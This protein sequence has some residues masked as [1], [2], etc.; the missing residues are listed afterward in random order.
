MQYHA[1]RD[2]D[3]RYS[4]QGFSLIELMIV[5]AIIGILAAVVLPAYSDYTKR[6]KMTEVIMAASACRTAITEVYQNAPIS[7][8]VQD[9]WGCEQVSSP[10]KNV[11]SVRTVDYGHIIVTAQNF[12]D[13][14][15][16]GRSIRL[17]PTDAN[18]YP[19]ITYNP[20]STLVRGWKCGPY[21]GTL[22]LAA[23]FLPASCRN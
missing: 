4:Q 12:G 2:I 10:S 22:G 16:D 18:G 8:P 11:A 15:I 9:S 17:R 1:K 7:L 14:T 20:G 13:A 5:V 3:G 6:A 21:P 23:K 19:I